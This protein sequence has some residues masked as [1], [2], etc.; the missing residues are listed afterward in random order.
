MTRYTKALPVLSG[1]YSVETAPKLHFVNVGGRR[2]VLKDTYDLLWPLR[3]RRRCWEQLRIE[4]PDVRKEKWWEIVQ[5]LLDL[6]VIEDPPPHLKSQ[7]RYLSALQR[8]Y[9]G[10]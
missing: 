2:L 1:L 4:F 10:L 5:G 6:H 9:R 7:K 3:F 8:Q